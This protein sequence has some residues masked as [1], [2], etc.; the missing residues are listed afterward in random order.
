MDAKVNGVRVVGAEA[1]PLD[2]DELRGTVIGRLAGVLDSITHSVAFGRVIGTMAQENLGQI[3]QRLNVGPEGTLDVAALT[4]IR[5]LCERLELSRSQLFVERIHL[6]DACL[7]RT[8]RAIGEFNT[9]FELM[10]GA[11][12]ERDLLERQQ[13][14]LEHV[15]LSHSEFAQWD[16]FVRAVLLDLYTEFPFD[17]FYA[18][19][20]DG[21]G[22]VL[23]SYEAGSA[24]QIGQDARRR[25]ARRAVDAMGVAAAVGVKV[26]NLDTGARVQSPEHKPL[27]SVRVAGQTSRSGHLVGTA[28]L[29]ET[30][31][32]VREQSVI[33]SILTALMIVLESS[34][35]L[36]HTMDELTHDATHDPL[37]GLYNRRHFQTMIEYEINQAERRGQVFSILMLDLD[38]FKNINDSYGHPVGDAVLRGVADAVQGVIRKGDMG[39]RLGGDEFAI[40]LAE[41]NRDGAMRVAKKLGSALRERTFQEP[42]GHSFHVTTSIGVV[43]YPEDARSASELI[44]GVD[45]AMYRAKKMGKDATCSMGL[46][47]EPLQEAKHPRDYIE[48][49]RLALEEKRVVPY[50][51]PIIDCR[52]GMLFASEAM[53]RMVTYENDVIA[54]VRFIETV[55][56]HGLGYE[57]DCVIIEHALAMLGEGDESQR[58]FIN[59]APQEIQNQDFLPHVGDLC[60]QFEIAPERLV[61]EIMAHDVMVDFKATC[62]FI[63]QLHAEGFAFALDDFGGGFGASIN[64]L[65]KMKVEYVKID[66][67]LID[68]IG[69][70]EVNWALVQNFARLCQDLGISTVGKSVESMEILRTLRL[71]GIDYVQGY[72]PGAPQPKL[73]LARDFGLGESHTKK[74]NR[75]TQPPSLENPAE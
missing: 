45:V 68:S 4:E 49:M 5:G 2:L 69:E 23:R 12:V 18:L 37:T 63:D 20:A 10:E 14:V 27:L 16:A 75:E 67:S 33:R 60:R 31:L 24:G 6:Y 7:D 13:R 53:A 52:S 62:S 36:S 26:F 64:Y 66:G 48:D 28:F 3:A 59:L 42:G 29:S 39:T 72:H 1:A 25:L 61:F 21:N 19:V 30:T 47:H 73:P 58:L 8:V 71:M 32:N 40:L 57:L 17:V 15:I 74:Q 44:A 56:R 43:C 9:M 46:A 38:D 70:S 41:T 22:Y 55:E 11:L 54:A 34:R 35:S 65:R 50:F 51:Q